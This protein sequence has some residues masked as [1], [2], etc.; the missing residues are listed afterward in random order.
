MKILLQDTR[1]NASLWAAFAA[2]MLFVLAVTVYTGAT[3]YSTYQTAQ[4]ELERAAN[5]SVDA[6]LLNAN[7]RDLVLD[8]P[9]DSAEQKVSANLIS[10][11]FAQEEDGDW[12]R[13]QDGKPRYHLNDMQITVSGKELD[14]TATLVM[15]LPW[16]TGSLSTVK[17][18]IHVES[19]VLYLD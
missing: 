4:T 18:P 1:G 8:I 15:P 17:L 9:A 11:G 19:Q 3:L 2:A 12:A 16:A 5:V 10:Q 6:S 7:V 14:I 13:I